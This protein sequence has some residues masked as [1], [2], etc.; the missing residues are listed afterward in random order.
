M[1]NLK[2]PMAKQ[3]PHWIKVWN[4]FCYK[5][6][7]ASQ[8]GLSYNYDN[9]PLLYYWTQA[10]SLLIMYSI[11]TCVL[12]YTMKKWRKERPSLTT[13]RPKNVDLYLVTEKM[14]F[15]FSVCYC[16]VEISRK[17]KSAVYWHTTTG[18]IYESK[19][20]GFLWSWYIVDMLLRDSKVCIRTISSSPI[21]L[22]SYLSKLQENQGRKEK[23]EYF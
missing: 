23:G 15:M 8:S 17:G 18:N 3:F 22:L 13:N 1:Y 7:I 14:I 5:C 2:I 9:S 21:H 10:K 20:N 19:W 4:S 11:K 12:I 6:N 16:D